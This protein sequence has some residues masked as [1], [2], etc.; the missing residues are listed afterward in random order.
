MK[1]SVIRGQECWQ[2]S[3]PTIDATVTVQG[4][5]MAPVGF[6]LPGGRVVQ[7]YYVS[8]W[9]DEGTASETAANLALNPVANPAVSQ[10]IE[11]A[12]LVPLR[13]DFFCLP[14][15]GGNKVGDEDHQ[16]HGE[17]AWKRWNFVSCK[18]DEAGE[19]PT[20]QG[21]AGQGPAGQDL[22]GVRASGGNPATQLVLG[23]DYA[24][25]KGSV[26]KSLFIGHD[27]AYIGTE[28]TLSGFS[29]AYP[30][31]HHATLAGS[32]ERDGIWELFFPPFDLG[33]TDPDNTLPFKGGEYY[34]LADG[35]E[36]HD[37]S[38]VPTRWKNPSSVDLSKFPAR[39][40]FMDIAA[41]YRKSASAGQE[42]T[43]K[44][45]GVDGSPAWLG[46]V[47]WTVAVNR[48]EG[49]LWYSIK[50]Q[51]QLP[52]TVFWMENQGR[53]AYPWSGRNSCIGLEETCAFMA[54]GRSRSIQSNVVSQHG[55]P[56][57]VQLSPD[58]PLRV[59]TIQGV[60][61]VPRKDIRITGLG[62]DAAGR[63]V[64][65]SDTGPK[66]ALPVSPA[67]VLA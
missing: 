17:S 62:I 54:A 21:L 25:C 49:Y 28:H 32:T 51:S 46:R 40:G 13:G 45:N 44:G 38:V 14:F 35:V 19:G 57:A 48:E 23:M 52:A 53:H 67:W 63:A 2:V 15:G 39:R 16:P 47:G 65:A 33:F 3:T 60:L 37:F 29:G 58:K 50:D 41:I 5:M 42:D 6:T 27:Q 34:A 4:G 24:A 56:T 9:Q 61:P 31:G 18:A 66:L 64:F 8:P 59:R 55:I 10:P 36:F 30:L 11:P 26:R 1:T 20:R 7:P 43:D 22:S 12:V